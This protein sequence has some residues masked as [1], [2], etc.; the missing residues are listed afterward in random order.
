MWDAAPGLKGLLT[1]HQELWSRLAARG[2]WGGWVAT[3]PGTVDMLGHGCFSMWQAGGVG[4]LRI[5]WTRRAASLPEMHEMFPSTRVFPG[6]T[7]FHIHTHV[8]VLKKGCSSAGFTSKGIDTKASERKVTIPVE[9]EHG[10]G[11]GSPFTLP[12]RRCTTLAS[13]K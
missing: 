1:S 13:M 9:N 12:Q 3:A 11:G 7:H 5:C 6:H 2:T 8:Y 4:C 10:N